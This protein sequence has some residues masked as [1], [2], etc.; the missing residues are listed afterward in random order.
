MIWSD[1]FDN[2]VDP[3]WRAEGW[4]TM[5]LCRYLDWLVL[6]KRPQNILRFLP[7]GWGSA[8]WPQCWMGV[9]VENQTEAD[10]RIPILLTIPARI[11]WLSVE[12]LLGPVDL[13]RWLAAGPIHFVVVGGES[14]P[15]H[16]PMELDWCYDLLRQCAEYGVAFFFK[17]ISATHPKDSMIP[18]DL[19]VRQFPA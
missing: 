15:H 3:A 13:R 1:F 2:Q 16:R 18:A 19:M 14:G 8:G 7:P 12:P 11:R 4:M 9:S 6:T 17:Q 5:R 10:R